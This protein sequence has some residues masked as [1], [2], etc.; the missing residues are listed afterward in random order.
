MGPVVGGVAVA[1]GS[2]MWDAMSLSRLTKQAIKGQR[3]I[4]FGVGFDGGTF[5]GRINWRVRLT[6]RRSGV[7]GCFAKALSA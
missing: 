5:S 2:V 4:W 7:V 1:S 6:T 3:C